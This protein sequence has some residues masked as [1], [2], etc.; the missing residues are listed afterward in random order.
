VLYIVFREKGVE[1]A[2]EVLPR[3]DVLPIALR[4]V[5]RKLIQAAAI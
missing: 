2:A 4:P 5:D 3:L 1:A